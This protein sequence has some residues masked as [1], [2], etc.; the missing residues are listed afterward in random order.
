[1]IYHKKNLNETDNNSPNSTL[2]TLR[3]TSTPKP[4]QHGLPHAPITTFLRSQLPMRT[5]PAC[6]CTPVS[7]I[8]KMNLFH[9]LGTFIWR[10]STD[11][12]ASWYRLLG[13][14]KTSMVGRMRR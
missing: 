4:D 12:F 14:R 10:S 8:N 6:L 5:T 3:L 1:M 9:R 2:N 13:E 11:P 7:I